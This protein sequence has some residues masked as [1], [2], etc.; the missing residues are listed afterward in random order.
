MAVSAMYNTNSND[1]GTTIEA[2]AIASLSAPKVTDKL[3]QR[4]RRGYLFT[5]FGTK[6]GFANDKFS[7]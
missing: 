5:K 2:E 3:L 1:S 6:F 4:L 7:A